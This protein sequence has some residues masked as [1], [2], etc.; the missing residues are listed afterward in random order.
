MMALTW[1]GSRKAV[2]RRPVSESSAWS[3]GGTRRWA[4]RN[5]RFGQ[6][7]AAAS[8]TAA[9]VEGTVVSKPTAVKTVSWPGYFFGDSERRKRRGDNIDGRTLCLDLSKRI[10]VSGHAERSPNVA[11][12]MCFLKRESGEEVEIRGRGDAHR[13][14][15]PGNQRNVFREQLPDAEP[16]DLHGVR[17]AHLHDADAAAP[18]ARLVMAAIRLRAVSGS[19][20]ACRIHGTAVFSKSSRMSARLSSASCSSYFWMAS[21]A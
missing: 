20:N 1:P 21:P 15:G 3:A 2:I 14:A 8:R 11:M 9:A 18:R 10:A 12:R 13:A 4:T 5:E 16:P 19:R 17:A 7:C 6:F